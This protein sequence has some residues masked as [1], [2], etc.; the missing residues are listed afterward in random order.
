MVIAMFWTSQMHCFKHVPHLLTRSWRTP[1]IHRSAEVINSY[2]AFIG[3]KNGGGGDYALASDND[4]WVHICFHLNKVILA[5]KG[6][7]ESPDFYRPCW[8]TKTLNCSD[9]IME[10]QNTWDQPLEEK[11]SNLNGKRPQFCSYIRRNNLHVEH[12]ESKIYG[13]GSYPWVNTTTW[14]G[15]LGGLTAMLSAASAPGRAIHA[16]LVEE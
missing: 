15:G 14:W 10:T 9:I 12:S 8:N 5:Q 3:L 4:I 13:K 16:T 11:P 7:S 1:E 2:Y 6:Y